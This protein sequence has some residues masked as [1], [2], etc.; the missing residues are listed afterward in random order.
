MN[1]NNNNNNNNNNSNINNNNNNNS[2]NSNRNNLDK[3][4]D[5][6]HFENFPLFIDW[7]SSNL[8]T[9]NPKLLEG[10]LNVTRSHIVKEFFK[11]MEYT[12]LGLTGN[13]RALQ[14]NTI[15]NNNSLQVFGHRINPITNQREVA[16]SNIRNPDIEDLRYNDFDYNVQSKVLECMAILEVKFNRKL[17]YHEITTLYSIIAGGKYDFAFTRHV[18]A[19]RVS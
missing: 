13:M 3:S 16:L 10:N 2:N 6:I 5:P 12:D 14:G 18:I 1:D 15:I 4:N 7:K 11:V 9:I 8:Q 17:Y 19:N